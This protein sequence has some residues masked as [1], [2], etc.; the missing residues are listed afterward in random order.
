LA[1]TAPNRWRTYETTMD[2]GTR[3][4]VRADLRSGDNKPC[5]YALVALVAMVIDG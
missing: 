2:A 5:V 4:P 3:L 1:L